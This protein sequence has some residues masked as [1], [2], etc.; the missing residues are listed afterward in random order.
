MKTKTFRLT[1]EVEID[2]Q[3]ETE[4]HL[5]RQLNRVI[6]NA[7]N[8]GLITG[9]SMATVEEYRYSVKKIANFTRATAV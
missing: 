7:L 2:P 4:N 6:S 5:K 8:Q 9:D 1:L 3:G